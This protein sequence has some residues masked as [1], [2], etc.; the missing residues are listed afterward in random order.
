[1]VEISHKNGLKVIINIIPEGAPYWTEKENSN[2]FYKTSKNESLNYSGPANIP[3][4]GLPGLCLDN[5]DAQELMGRFIYETAK[6]FADHEAIISFDVWNEPH[7]EP[8]FDYSGELLCYCDGL[9]QKFRQWLKDKYRTIEVLNNTWFRCY[10]DWEQVMP[11][12]RF[13]TYAAKE[14]EKYTASFNGI[15]EM[16]YDAGIPVRF[17]HKDT[18]E[19]AIDGGLKVLY[20]PMAFAL[21]QDE[22]ETL[23]MFVENGGRLILDPFAGMY[24]ENG[25]MDM[26]F[27]FLNDMFEMKNITVD[28]LR[29]GKEVCRTKDGKSFACQYYRQLYSTCNEDVE[30]LAEFDDG[31]PSA[32]KRNMGQGSVICFNGYIGA[33]YTEFRDAETRDYLLPL[34]E[35]NGYD[36]VI[37]Q[38]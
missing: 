18:L 38:I 8:M 19:K 15:Y 37:M 12:P 24:K 21:T 36:E 17:V 6:H 32:V 27:A 2:S 29:P 35:K 4:A 31:M 5:E 20:L 23:K 34:F 14:E 11:P 13:G 1:L 25:E 33:M 16:L 9:I 26:K 30:V 7:L 3:S 28:A 10:T 22:Q